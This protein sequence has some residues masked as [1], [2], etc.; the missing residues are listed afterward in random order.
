MKLTKVFTIDGSGDKN[1]KTAELK[2]PIYQ[3]DVS[4]NQVSR[5]PSVKGR[6][7]RSIFADAIEGLNVG[8]TIL[9]AADLPIGIPVEPADVYRTCDPPTFIG[10]LDSLVERCRDGNWRE[11]MIAKGV[12]NRS[13]SQPFVSLGKGEQRGGWD[14]KRRCDIAAKAESIY[15]VDHGPKQVGKSALQFWW[16]VMMPIRAAY[17]GKTAIWPMEDPQS[18]SVIFAECYPALCQRMLFGGNVSKRN[19]L[20]VAT[21]L[22]DL[23]ANHETRSMAD[24][25]TWIHAAS[26]EDEFDMFV[27]ALAIAR[28][29]NSGVD[30]FAHP[31]DQAIQTLEGWILG[32]RRLDSRTTK[33]GF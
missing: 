12:A 21:A 27:T 26:S 19:A 22:K 16:D 11:T 10:W 28:M 1:R 24:I 5:V 23:S 3:W 9:V 2:R 17:P 31:D 29:V 18:A 15:C 14:G 8:E 33:V 32:Q 7:A 6:T 25:A 4:V 13:A 30:L 20:A